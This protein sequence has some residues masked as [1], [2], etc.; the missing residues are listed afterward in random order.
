MK[1]GPQNRELILLSELWYASGPLLAELHAVSGLPTRP[2]LIVIY[3]PRSGPTQLS[4]RPVFSDRQSMVPVRNQ[5]KCQPIQ[6]LM[7]GVVSD[8]HT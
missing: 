3:G 2:V 8:Q 1:L 6:Y 4:T 5:Q 7:A